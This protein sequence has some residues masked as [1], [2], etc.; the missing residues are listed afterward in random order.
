MI[1]Y[2]ITNLINQKV[3]IGQTTKS[4]EERMLQHRNA[5]VSH[6]KT[7]LYGAM[8]KYGWDNFKFEVIDTSAQTKEELDNLER[9]YISKYNSMVEGYNMTEGGDSN[10]MDCERSREKHDR[11][12][13]SVEVRSKISDSM[14]A[15]YAKRGGPTVEHRLNLSKQKKELYASAKGDE[16][17]AKFRASYVLTPEHL[18]AANEGRRKGVYCI[19]TEGNVVATFDWVKEAAQW[20]YDN[21]YVVKD[22]NGLCDRIKESFVKDK[23][24][25]GLKWIYTDKQAGYRA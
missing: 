12:M 19:D 4:L 14:K 13:R 23:Y 16:V 17:R 1:I 6:Q 11:V 8:H 10:P 7:Y 2:K 15:S 20:W 25:R 3:Y 24:I 5:F 9:Y 22:V 18:A 21:G